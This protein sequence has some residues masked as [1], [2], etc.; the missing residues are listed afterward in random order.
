[1][2]QST[3]ESFVVARSGK[4]RTAA[5]LMLA[6]LAELRVQLTVIVYVLNMALSLPKNGTVARAVAFGDRLSLCV[7]SSTTFENRGIP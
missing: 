3:S 1:M 7:K 2:G 5:L 6:M 4:P